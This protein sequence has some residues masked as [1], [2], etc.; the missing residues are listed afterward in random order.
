MA[1]GTLLPCCCGATDVLRPC[2]FG[3][4]LHCELKTPA[5]CMSLGG[6]S[7]LNLTTCN[8]ADVTTVCHGN[9]PPPG[10][11]RCGIGGTPIAGF[12]VSVSFTLCPAWSCSVLPAPCGGAKTFTFGNC[13]GSFCPY[14]GTFNDGFGVYCLYCS[15]FGGTCATDYS[16]TPNGS[17]SENG[18]CA[19]C[20]RTLPPP[21]Y[22]LFTCGVE[23]QA[24]TTSVQVASRASLV[25]TGPIQCSA[26]GCGTYT[27]TGAVAL[28]S[29]SITGADYAN[30]C[31]GQT[32]QKV[33]AAT[34]CTPPPTPGSFCG[35]GNPG[36][37]TIAVNGS[38][39]YSVTRIF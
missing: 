2:C 8:H 38:A 34:V 5:E 3:D 30:L 16:C 19:G 29:V 15:N 27:A 36:N 1:G 23:V 13:G 24:T 22:V 21:P 25:H 10:T 32:V 26:G 31:A 12:L 35:Q 28:N 9:V 4:P 11:C 7:F 39:T 18:G 17:V 37:S 6:T 14:I 33:T 20:R